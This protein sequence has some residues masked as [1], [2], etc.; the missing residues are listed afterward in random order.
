MDANWITAIVVSL[1]LMFW[2]G[3]LLLFAV[4]PLA[5]FF[6]QSKKKW[7]ALVELLMTLPMVLPPTVLGFYLLMLFS[8]FD[9]VG[10][11]EFAFSFKGVVLA[12]FIQVMPF[13]LQPLIQFFKS[14]P[15]VQVEH[16]YYLKLNIY[17]RFL[18]VIFP[19]SSNMILSLLAIGMAQSLSSF[20][21]VLMVGG[22]LSGETKVASVLLF[23]KVQQFQYAQAN[24]LAIILVLI[25][26]C[27][28]LLANKMKA[29]TEKS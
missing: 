17:Q 13:Y 6:S 22:G 29:R 25:S 2:V 24:T 23:E 15:K 18:K 9:E 1:K 7:I 26:T 8:K 4:T 16:S 3:A 28:L 21:V 10:F 11:V 20:G 19:L 14:L 27:L 5:W 12:V